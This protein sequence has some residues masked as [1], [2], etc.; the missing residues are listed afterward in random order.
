LVLAKIVTEKGA[1]LD[2][3]YVTEEDG[4]PLSSQARRKE[5]AKRLLAAVAGSS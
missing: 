4:T 5:V 1:A 3:F 2:T